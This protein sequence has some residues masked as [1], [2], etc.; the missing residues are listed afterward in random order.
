MRHNPLCGWILGQPR[1]AVPLKRL[2]YRLFLGFVGLTQMIM[3]RLTTELT[4]PVCLGVMVDPVTLICGHSTCKRCC[5]LAF[6]LSP[7]CP[8]G[9]GRV[10]PRLLPEVN[11]ALRCAVQRRYGPAY[12]ERV[13]EVSAAT[14]V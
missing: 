2:V 13:R 1:A 11:V 10:M 12:E 3:A 14:L 6:E 7:K 9:C 5:G 4:C 8:A